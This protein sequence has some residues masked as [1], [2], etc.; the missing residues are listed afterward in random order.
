MPPHVPL[1]S[2]QPSCSTIKHLRASDQAVCEDTV[3]FY[4]REKTRLEAKPN[5]YAKLTQRNLYLGRD[6]S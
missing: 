6:D 1:F 2:G 5:V 4:P 3:D